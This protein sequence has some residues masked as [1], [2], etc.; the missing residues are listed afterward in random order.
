MANHSYVTIG[1]KLN[2]YEAEQVLREIVFST[3]DPTLFMVTQREDLEPLW[4]KARV[5]WVHIPGSAPAGNP[6]QPED[7]GFLVFYHVRNSMW[8]FRH[9][10]NMWERW[11]QSKVKYLL[12][13]RFGAKI[14]EDAD[15]KVRSAKSKDAKEV[16]K[17]SSFS[18]YLRRNFKNPLK[19]DDR[20]W[21][22]KLLDTWAPP[23]C[24]T[25]D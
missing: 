12:A 21:L 24:R 4:Q 6:M 1:E 2:G 22:Q 19:E 10:I 13:Q 23:G 3:F 15:D 25:L 17:H 16:L 5:W 11:C 14:L 18:S 20:A 9:P 7:Y 8:E